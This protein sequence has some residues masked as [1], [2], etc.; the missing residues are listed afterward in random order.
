MLFSIMKSM[1]HQ[2]ITFTATHPQFYS[3]LLH[4]VTF[5]H[6]VFSYLMLSSQSPNNSGWKGSLGA[7]GSNFFKA[8]LYQVRFCRVLFSLAEISFKIIQGWRFHSLVQFSAAPTARTLFCCEALFLILVL[9]TFKKC[10][11]SNSV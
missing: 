8:Q 1:A 9:H 11:A 10:L 2:S 6:L 4:C 7:L 3:L 5:P